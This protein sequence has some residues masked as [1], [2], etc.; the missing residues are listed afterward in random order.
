MPVVVKVE[1]QTA[2]DVALFAKGKLCALVVGATV[3]KD[4][5]QV[6]P[7]IHWMLVGPKYTVISILFL[8][9]VEPIHDH[10][11]VHW[12]LYDFEVIGQVL[13]KNIDKQSIGIK[14]M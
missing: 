9:V 5:A 7:E 4:E 11:K 14:N 6:A 2:E 8:L 3:P 13:T 12:L 1:S 10:D